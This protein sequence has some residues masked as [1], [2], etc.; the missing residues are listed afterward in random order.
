MYQ[1][2]LNQGRGP[3]PA[4]HNPDNQES[5]AGHWQDVMDRAAAYWQRLTEADIERARQGRQHLI[6]V[7][8]ERYRFGKCEADRHIEEF[9]AREPRHGWLSRLFSMNGDLH[10]NQYVSNPAPGPSAR[11]DQPPSV[12]PPE[13]EDRPAPDAP[14]RRQD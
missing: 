8:Q 13:D 4:E 2:P 3:Q 11:D 5:L 12:L 7:L 10:V 9:L 14:D 6:A 1:D